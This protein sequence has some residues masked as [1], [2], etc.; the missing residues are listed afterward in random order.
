[1]RSQSLTKLQDYSIERAKESLRVFTNRLGYNN[2]PFHQEWYHYLQHDFS[3]LKTHPD[4]AK[5]FLLLWPRGHAKTESTSINY[6]S[7]MAGRYRD[8]HINLVTKTASLAEEILTALIT[9]FESDEKYKDVFG[10]LKPSRPK[11]WTSREII[12]D[13]DEISKNPTLKA[14]GLM[15][16]IT[17]GRSDLIVCD[18]IIDEENVRTRLQL[19]KVSTWFNKVLYPT[20]YPWGGIIVIGTRWSYADIYAEL[21][22]KWPHDIKQAI[23]NDGNALWPTYWPVS[24]LDERRNEIGTIFF[25]CQYQNDPTG[26]EGA[27]LP[28]KYLHPYETDPPANLM[29]YAAIDPAL[30]EGDLQAVATMGHDR[31]TKQGYLLD[32]WAEKL[33]FPMFLKKVRDLHLTHKYAKIFVESNAFQKVLTFVPELRQG[34]PIVPSVTDRDKERRFIAM[35]S[36]FEAKR[37]LVNPLL[38]RRGEFWHEWVQ[39]PRGQY[40]DALD[41]VEIV[42]RNVI[43]VPEAWVSRIDW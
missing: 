2:A 43:S 34:L 25:N 10:S 24:R 19:E 16:P 8:I 13:R 14:T 11:K 21:L 31:V 33:T 26:M 18:D 42:T 1:M 6:T 12:V 23:D 29:R 35:S 39:F 7:W 41:A 30:G 9:R 36:H 27:L 37:V 28:A 32:V 17:G 22:E 20:L 40:D 38:L 3:P 15:G 4:A 5:K